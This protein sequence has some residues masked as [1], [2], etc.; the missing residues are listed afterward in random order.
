MLKG[1]GPSRSTRR[2]FREVAAVA[3]TSSLHKLPNCWKDNW[4]FS[5][6]TKIILAQGIVVLRLLYL[7]YSLINYMYRVCPISYLFLKATNTETESKKI[8]KVTNKQYFYFTFNIQFF[9]DRKFFCVSDALMYNFECLA[10][11]FWDWVLGHFQHIVRLY[12]SFLKQS[13]IKKQ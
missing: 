4:K 7:I 11:I 12:I 9:R 10:L 8:T 6:Y 13:T 2:L 1:K 5:N 3:K